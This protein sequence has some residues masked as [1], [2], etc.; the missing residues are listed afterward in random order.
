MA[1]TVRAYLDR[2]RKHITARHEIQHYGPGI[3][4]I[5]EAMAVGLRAAGVNIDLPATGNPGSAPEPEKQG[6]PRRPAAPAADPVVTLP[7]DLPGRDAL[8][9]AGLTTPAA[10]LAHPDL[11]EIAGIGKATAAKIM[12]ALE[13]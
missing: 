2:E 5:P 4:D 10:V 13:A 9:A 12:A 8:E 11:T 6:E 1:G 7:A 3:V